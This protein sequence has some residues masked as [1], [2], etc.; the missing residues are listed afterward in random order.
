MPND[1]A[2]LD[3][4]DRRLI[5]RELNSRA[6]WLDP[7]EPVTPGHVLRVAGRGGD[8]GAIGS[9]LT[10]LGYR[11]PSPEQ[12]AS[13]TDDDLKMISRDIDGLAP[14]IRPG[15][16][17][18]L[19]GHILE[20][21]RR[22]NRPPAE[23]A[24]RLTELGHPAPA[25]D[26]FPERVLDEDRDLIIHRDGNSPERWIPDDTLV[27]LGH[28]I[29]VLQRKGKLTRVP[30][31]T[32]SEIASVC[33]RLTRLGYRIHPGTAEATAD[34]V[35]LISRELDGDAPWLLDQDEP[36][37]LH[38]V[39]RFTQA[40]DRDPNEVLARLGRLGYRRLPE[41]PLAG[42]VDH[43][44]IGLLG[45]GWERGE[46]RS[47]LAQDDPAWFPHLL[48]AG[49]RTGRALA[50][51]ADRLRALGYVIPEQEF[52]AEVSESDF[53]LVGG[54]DITGAEY[55]LSRT[56]PVPAGHVLYTAHA[57]GV[58]AASVLARL[59]EL[60]YTRLPDVP[61][62]HVTEDDLRLISERG[63]GAAPVLG[64]TVPYGR[65]LRAAADSG[66]GPR[67]IADRYRELGYT[68]VVLPDGPLPG[69]V[70][71][72][73]AGLAATDTGW[74]HPDEPVPLPHVVRRAHAEGVGPADVARRLH[75]L[76][77][78]KVPAPLPDTPHPGD[79]AMISQDAEPGKPYIPLTGV[80][81]YHVLCAANAAEVSLHDVAVRLIALG[82]T[83]GFTPHPDDAVILSENA[84]G[85]APWL[86]WPY[87]GRAL[88]AAKVLGRTPE[89]IN[90]R[91][92]ELRG[93]ESDLPDAG[94]FEEED[95]LLLSKE[96]DARAPW[97]SE[98]G[99]S[100]LE[101]V[102]RA[103]R[104][105]GRSPQEIGERLTLLGHEVQV[106]PALDVRDGDL[107]ELIT[108]F[109]KPVGAADVLAV[110]SRTGRSPAEVAARLR[111]L[112]VEVPDLAYPTRRPAPT[113][114][115][116]P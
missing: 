19:R 12:L 114:P 68:D 2:S 111:E 15:N 57:R 102:L 94:G 33:E 25:P 26:S 17:G 76:G 9:R 21:A 8:P 52:P 7:E 18:H 61:D 66:T 64:D 74:L 14:W 31:Q 115:R 106:P 96:L 54:R 72:R 34:D 47:W 6:P 24:A 29:A 107:L 44:D 56:D 93:R 35:V 16:D 82:Y 89:E 83:L 11:V 4:H 58:S 81:A 112:D 88:L 99:A 27:T 55:W 103:A 63:D 51:I 22:L 5:S 13:V 10:E 95:I 86:L 42:S 85:R 78:H 1:P 53:P 50:E 71:E 28:V 48:A 23:I 40:H 113:P 110:A 41:G 67:E 84:D 32:A 60:G 62:R 46:P 49:A 92:G 59:A 101:H 3:H 79:L 45:Y 39:L 70:P 97:L 75:A 105:T 104:V 36:V 30:Q 108:R 100:L 38:H 65:L 87:L 91:I 77:F 37:P 80:P 90:D 116:L 98:R 73:D 69:S 43:K 20:A 109:G